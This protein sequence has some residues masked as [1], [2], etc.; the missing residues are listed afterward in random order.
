LKDKSPAFQWYPKQALG[1]DKIIAMDWDAKG[2][3]YTLCW[4]SWQQEPA[5]TIP[6]ETALIRRWLGSPSDDIW[7]RVSPQVFA[8]WPIADRKTHPEEQELWGRRVNAGMRRAWE[9]QQT[10]KQNGSKKGGKAEL[11]LEDE[12]VVKK[13]EN[14]EDFKASECAPNLCLEMGLSGQRNWTTATDAIVTF[15]HANPGKNPQ[16]ASEDL[17]RLWAIYRASPKYKRF[18]MNPEKWLSSGEF[19][20]S[21]NWNVIE[22]TEPSGSPA[23]T[24]TDA[25][26]MIRDRQQKIKANRA[27]NGK[28]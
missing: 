10:Y 18:P 21:E 12:V 8:A 3:H 11:P 24:A 6:D 7:R 16:L 14:N 1:D 9:R 22:T 25:S 2:M 27:S 5:G 20:R 4:L 13:K 15:V 26:E 23:V 17:G 28:S 19:L